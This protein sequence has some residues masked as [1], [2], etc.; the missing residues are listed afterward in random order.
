MPK[1][2]LFRGKRVEDLMKMDIREFAKLLNSRNKRSL[3]RQSDS[4]GKFLKKCE[5]NKAK[6]KKIK[7]QD[8]EVIIVPAMIDLMIYIHNG[9]EFISLKITP[10]LL[11]HR[12]GEFVPTRKKIEHSAPG[13][14]ATRSSASLSVK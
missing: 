12:L 14:G 7:T 5:K 10:E 2:F 4:I 13:V 1:E 11:G 3:L 8:R 9:K 6:G